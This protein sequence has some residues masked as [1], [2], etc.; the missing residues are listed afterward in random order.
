MKKVW[1][2]AALLMVA[3]MLFSLFGLAGLGQDHRG[4]DHGRDRHPDRREAKDRGKYVEGCPLGLRVDPASGSI[5]FSP[6]TVLLK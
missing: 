3:A 6:A 1:R 2:V 4:R 5:V